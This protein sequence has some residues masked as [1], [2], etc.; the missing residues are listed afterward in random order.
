VKKLLN[1]NSDERVGP[2]PTAAEIL[3]LKQL[4]AAETQSSEKLNFMKTMEVYIYILINS[5]YYRIKASSNRSY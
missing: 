3:C 2:L 1:Q 4:E 5:T